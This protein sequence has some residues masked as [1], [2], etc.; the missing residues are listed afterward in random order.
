MKTN[1]PDVTLYQKRLGLQTATFSRIDHEDA[2]VAAV[3]KVTEANGKQFI[4]KIS[5]KNTHYFREVF[6]LEK[7]V[8]Q[9]PVPKILRTIPPERGVHGAILM[10]YLPGTLLK[11]SE[12]N[13]ACAYE[14]GRC[15]ALI[16]QNR[17]PSYGDPTEDNMDKPYFRFALAEDSQK[18]MIINWLEQKHIKEWIHGVGLQNTLNDLEQFFKGISRATYWIG[19]DQSIPFAF[20][21]TSPEGED[22]VTLDV[23]ICDFNYKGQGFAA[24]MIREFLL[25]QCSQV[26]RVLI[27]PEKTNTRAIHVYQKVGFKIIDEFIASWHPV[28][29]YLMELE[30][31]KLNR[32]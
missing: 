16:H 26:K 9:V 23:F 32:A 18:L 11:T 17:F 15:L 12:I 31:N 2:I 6:F 7:L 29:H 19:Y 3:Y 21:I 25:R 14:L 28:P 1:C 27:D 4:L 22:A 13:E 5:D 30:M 10:E 24:S 8:N 20:L